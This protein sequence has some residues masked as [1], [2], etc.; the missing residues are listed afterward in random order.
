M[1]LKGL[2]AL[3]LILS[4]HAKHYLIK[5]EGTQFFYKDCLTCVYF[6]EGS[7]PRDYGIVRVPPSPGGEPP[8]RGGPRWWDYS[9]RPWPSPP[10][11]AT[12]FPPFCC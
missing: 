7:P 11:P 10:G 2:T 3:V 1:M 8:P 12:V 9:R 5:T 4:I 6:S